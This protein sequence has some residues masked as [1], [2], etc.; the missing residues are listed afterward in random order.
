MGGAGRIGP[1][2]YLRPRRRRPRPGTVR[3]CRLIMELKLTRCT[4]RPWRVGD[5][6]S[7]VRNANNR[8]VWRNLSRLPHP[9]T[10]ADA[11][12]WIGRASAQSPLPDVTVYVEA[13]RERVVGARLERLRLVNP[14][15][16]R[17]VDPPLSD[18]VG[19]AVTGVS[20]LGKRIVL[21]LPDERFVV[22]H[23]MIAGRLHWKAAG[24]R[25]PGKIGVAAFDFS[26]GTLV[27]T[28]AGTKKRAA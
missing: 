9:Y 8:R 15:V 11:D 24:A 14:F 16:L 5:E 6:A 26:T 10:T 13:L 12:D 4:L 22:I 17:S 27:M 18:V 3:K 21:A 23:L 2:L 25:P 1:R 19:R 28:E 7:L 20:R